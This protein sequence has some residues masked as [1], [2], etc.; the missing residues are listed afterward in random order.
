M[1]RSLRDDRVLTLLLMAGA[2]HKQTQG[3]DHDNYAKQGSTSETRMMMTGGYE[4][5]T[6]AGAGQ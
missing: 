2:R 5:S 1:E 3:L 4:L 6:G